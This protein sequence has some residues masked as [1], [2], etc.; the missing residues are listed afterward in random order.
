[1][2][3]AAV[4]DEEYASLGTETVAAKWKAD[5]AIVGEP[6]GLKIVTAHKGFAWF[7]IETRGVAAH[8]SLP[9]IGVDAIAKMGKVLVA[10][11]ELA[12]RLAE[13]RP[14]PLLGPGSVHASLIQGGQE[15]SSYPESCQL[16]VERRTI[17]GETPQSVEDELH[18]LLHD[19]GKGDSAF[20]ATLR[21]VFSREPLEVSWNEPLVRALQRAVKDE[22]GTAEAP[23]GMGGWMDSSLLAAAGIP[24]VVFGPTGEGLHGLTEWVDLS[25]VHACCRIVGEVIA[26]I[27]G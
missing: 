21:R 19:S 18:E 4:V 1:V 23:S 7:D 13:S 5:G 27:C 15:L 22:T 9:D 8:G 25:S 17:P 11:G 24:P 2:I 6:T 26:E 14:H 16:R 20:S 10:I 12:E 3:L